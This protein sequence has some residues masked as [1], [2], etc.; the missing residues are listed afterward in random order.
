MQRNNQFLYYY[1][2]YFPVS[3]IWI[4]SEDLHQLG[5]NMGTILSF[6]PYTGTY[7]IYSQDEFCTVNKI[8]KGKPYG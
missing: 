4:G 6:L 7:S 5:S 3:L 1:S 8:I 2:E